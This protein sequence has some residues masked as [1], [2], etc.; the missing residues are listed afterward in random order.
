MGPK[1]EN[2][3]FSLV[4]PLLFEGSRRPR[5]F[6]ENERGVEKCRLGGGRGRVR[7]L[8]FLPDRL[9]HANDPGGVGGLFLGDF[10]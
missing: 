6:Q 3:G 5:R 9:S 1:I 10:L 4:L 8:G 2:V 7:N